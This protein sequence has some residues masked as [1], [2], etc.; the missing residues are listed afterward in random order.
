MC[1]CVF[2]QHYWYCCYWSP[3][4][5]PVQ[6]PAAAQCESEAGRS[7]ARP[8]GSHCLSPR[9][10]SPPVEDQS[11]NQSINQSI[12]QPPIWPQDLF[13]LSNVDVLIVSSPC[14][15]SERGQTLSD[16]SESPQQPQ[17]PYSYLWT[18]NTCQNSTYT[19]VLYLSTNTNQYFNK[20]FSFLVTLFFYFILKYCP[21][22]Y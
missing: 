2:R 7:P 13:I 11:V 14:W 16:R 12:N 15:W 1:V 20:V 22:S 8:R 10:S 5:W 6:S 17:E 3:S 9:S 21:L 4:Y 18:H 19:Q